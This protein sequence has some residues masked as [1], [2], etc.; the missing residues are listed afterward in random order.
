MYVDDVDKNKCLEVWYRVATDVRVCTICGILILI[1]YL[2]VF[3]SRA[4]RPSYNRYSSSCSFTVL[5]YE[6]SNIN[7]AI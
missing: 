5:T 4:Q 2:L 1:S 6:L 7:V 3:T